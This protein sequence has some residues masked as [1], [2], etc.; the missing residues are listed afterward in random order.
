MKNAPPAEKKA[1]ALP[2]VQPRIEGETALKIRLLSERTN[3]SENRIANMAAEAGIKAVEK[4]F[5]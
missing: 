5:R 3:I 4:R 2:T 1:S